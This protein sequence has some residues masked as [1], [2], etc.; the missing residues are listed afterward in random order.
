MDTNFA[1]L[2]LNFSTVQNGSIHTFSSFAISFRKEIFSPQEGI[3][4]QVPEIF[5]KTENLK[6][7]G[8]HSPPQLKY[9]LK[10]NMNILSLNVYTIN[11]LCL[12]IL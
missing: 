1:I 12:Y 3:H 11:I 10:L 4:S 2:S 9:E 7:P 6:F 8:Q 5:S